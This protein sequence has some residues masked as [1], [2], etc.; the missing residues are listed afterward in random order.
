MT[1]DLVLRIDGAFPLTV[2]TVAAV[3]E[4]C[5]QAEDSGGRARVTA[6]VSG[7]PATHRPEGLTVALVSRWERALRRLERLP[8]ASV[9]VAEG[10]CG[11]T[12]LDVLLATD[13]RIA[14][15]TVR[16]VVPVEDGDTWPGMSLYRLAQQGASS[17]AIRR[18]VLFG[19]P[20]DGDQALAL[21]LIDVLEDDLPTALENACALTGAFEG[22]ELA[23]RRQLMFDAPTTSFDEALGAHLAACDRALRRHTAEGSAA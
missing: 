16:L 18:A 17:P 20:V 4:I 14:T 19:Q 1:H 22:S 23:I 10:E 6:H 7:A 9:A 12:A 5:D 2:E 11:G 3:N 15:P 13:Y 8:V 21:R